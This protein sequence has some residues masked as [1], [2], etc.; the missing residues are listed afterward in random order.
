MKQ[1][2]CIINDYSTSGNSGFIN[3]NF[4]QNITLEPYSSLALDKISTVILPSPSGQI[5]IEADQTIMITTQ[6]TGPRPSPRRS[7]I[8]PKG[9]YTYNE[10]TSYVPSSGAVA[11][12][13]LV[14]TL[15]KLFNGILIATPLKSVAN[16]SELDYGFGFK[17]TGAVNTATPP[18]YQLTLN[19][20][21]DKYAGA[22]SAQPALT[23][24]TN[25]VT[26]GAGP[27]KVG[28]PSGYTI[29]TP[30]PAVDTPFYIIDPTPIISGAVQCVVNI[31]IPTGF[32]GLINYGL[33]LATS[34]GN[35][36]VIVYGMSF[37][38]QYAYI[39]NNGQRTTQLPIVDFQGATQS[40]VVNMFMYTDDTTGN[41]RFMVEKPVGTQGYTTPVNSYTGY[42]TN[43]PY[44]IACNGNHTASDNAYNFYDWA[45]FH[46]PNITVDNNGIYFTEPNNKLYLTNNA[47]FVDVGVTNAPNRQVQIDLSS[48]QLLIKS[49]GLGL[50]ILQGNVSE[51]T[52]FTYTGITG[53]DFI[54]YYDLGLDV[55]NLSLETYV[56]FSNGKGSSKRNALAYFLMQRIS[57]IDSLFYAE[58][59]QMVFLSLNNKQAMNISSLQFRIYDCQTGLPLALTNGSF[60]IY[61]ADKGD[62]GGHDSMPATK[63]MEPVHNVPQ[64]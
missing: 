41:L 17:W 32:S 5:T 26:S 20:Y 7:V 22:T 61:V 36:P 59:K 30:S 24:L 49:L 42:N 6:N 25:F 48:S 14:D 27:V 50:N 56:G 55:L 58:Q 15:N 39:I 35:A 1:L 12:P 19:A 63:Y 31:R 60:N 54:N 38:G 52:P 23:P 4:N 46:Q 44:F 51:T 29:K 21:Q 43:T 45:A 16:N 18:V 9:T 33:C 13:D 57:D 40:A 37:E 28:T 62:G 34:A 11:V 10:T 64:F 47:S 53:V 2:K 8:L 3:I